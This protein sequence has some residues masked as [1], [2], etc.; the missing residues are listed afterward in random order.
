M[1]PDILSYSAAC[2]LGRGGGIDWDN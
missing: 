2:T 1:N